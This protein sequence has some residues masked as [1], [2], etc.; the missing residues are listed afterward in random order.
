M[1]SLKL[2]GYFKVPKE[3]IKGPFLASMRKNLNIS[4]SEEW[5]QMNSTPLPEAMEQEGWCQQ[6]D[7][8]SLSRAVEHI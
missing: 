7:T 5:S 4:E 2:Q 6:V 1:G 8:V 3:G